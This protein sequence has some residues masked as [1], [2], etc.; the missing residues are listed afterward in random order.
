MRPARKEGTWGSDWVTP[1]SLL[2]GLSWDYQPVVFREDWPQ[3]R[4]RD[5]LLRIINRLGYRSVPLAAL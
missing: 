1:E 3:D 2:P 4:I 5:C